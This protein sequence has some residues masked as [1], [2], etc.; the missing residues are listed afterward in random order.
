MRRQRICQFLAFLFFFYLIVAA[1]SLAAD[2]YL[3]PW[4]IALDPA[5]SLGTALAA[6]AI[7]T[8]MAGGLLVLAL[9][10][11]FGRVF[12][13]HV[14]PLG[15]CIDLAD[16]PFGRGKRSLP[17]LPRVRIFFFVLL[18][19]AACGGLS[20]LFAF[21]PLA[22]STRLLAL[23]G[24]PVLRLGAAYGV[25][26]L[27]PLG[28]HWNW[29]WLTFAQIR[30]PFYHL[31][32]SLLILTLAPIVGS[33]IA[34]RF[35]CRALCPAG[36]LFSFAAWRPALKREVS[37]SCIDCGLCRE[38]CP[39]EAI[40]KNPR[41]TRHGECITCRK[42]VGAC[43]VN[44]IRFSFSAGKPAESP[45]PDPARRTLLLGGVT[46]AAGG[47]LL[48]TSWGSA[49]SAPPLVRPPGARP[50]PDFLRRCIACGACMAACPTNTLQPSDLN[51]NWKA[52]LT[53]LLTP[54]VGPCRTDCSRCGQVCPTSAI[55]PLA[56]E[57]KI[58]ARPGTA[59][60]RRRRC[61]AW[62]EERAC[63][64]CDEVC[65]FDAIVLVRVPGISNPV[66]EVIASRC[67]GCGYCEH[68]C[69]VTGE[70]AIVV[71]PEGAVRLNENRHRQKGIETGL[72]IRLHADTDAGYP[73]GE[74]NPSELPPGFTP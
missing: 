22:I 16:H 68:E 24:E 36:A 23:L 39:T 53:P 65:P 58:W 72:D 14:C 71:I 34:P 69:P 21:A 37:E 30:T 70:R 15:A 10:L 43:P 62:L 57:E 40:G 66:P 6:R 60:I 61:I 48:S 17:G 74:E 11:I 7:F 59:H 52:L 46:L 19:G 35:W 49:I 38:N 20:L 28:D 4:F 32:F 12:C 64:V 27:R 8:G 26:F 45:L 3:L 73:S 18:F 13:G 44:A 47:A 9:T 67:S 5:A 63:L 33:L 54:V 1:G 56:P 2:Q 50:E 51:R 41:I 55:L 25:N 31:S 42:C 29:G